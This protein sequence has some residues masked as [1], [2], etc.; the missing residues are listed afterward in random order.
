MRSAACRLHLCLAAFVLIATTCA[1]ADD[2]HPWTFPRFS[3]DAAG[4]YKAASEVTPAAGTGVI[5]LDH[6][7][8][9]VLDDQGRAAYTMYAVYKTLT[10]DAAEQWGGISVEWEPWHENRPTIRARVITSDGIVHLLDG[11]TVT[12][13]AAGNVGDNVYSDRRVVQAALPA[14]APGS[15]IELEE[16]TNETA[17]AFTG[18]IVGRCLFGRAAPVQHFRLRLEAPVSVPLRYDVLLLPT[19]QAQRAESNGRLEITFDYGPI[20][21]L[22]A[23]DDDLPSDVPAY[24]SVEFS[25]GS[26]W[27]QIAGLYGGMVDRQIAQ[28]DLRSI[29]APLLKDKRTREDKITTLLQYSDREV[30][31][32]GI[33]FGA[34]AITPHTPSETLKQRFGDCKDKATLLIAMLRAAG[35]PSYMAL[36]Q[37]AERQDIRPDLPG[38]GRFDHAIVYVP[39]KPDVWIDATDERARLGE[40][41]AADQGRL[42]LIAKPETDSL[43]LTPAS[44][45]TDNLLVEKR[46]FYLAESGPARVVEI[47]E[48]HGQLE[49]AYRYDYANPDDKDTREGLTNYVANQYLAERLDKVSTSDPADITEQFTLTLESD[50]ARRGFT[51]L[52]SSGIAIRFDTLFN[53]LPSELQQH[54]PQPDKDEK[55]SK[56]EHKKPRTA[57]YQLPE[58]F[59]TEWHYT[60]VPPPGFRMKPL[61]QDVA[62]SLGPATLVEQFS[63]GS[64]GAAH[65]LIRFDTV[66]GR[67]TIA[68]ANEMRNKIADLRDAEPIE[69]NYEPIGRALLNEGKPRE[70]FQAYRDLIAAHPNDSIF[71]LWIAKDLLAAGLGEAA[72]DEARRAVKLAPDSA[73]AQ[74]ALAEILECDLVGRRYHHG[75]DFVGAAT[76]YRAAQK[77][78][79]N[80]KYITSSLGLLLSYNNEGEL[81][82][83]GADLKDAISEYHK[84]TPEEMSRQGIANNLAFCFFYSGDF[85]KAIENARTLNPQPEAIIVAA[86]AALHGSQAGIEEARKQSSNEA[87]VKE[88]L[89]TAGWMLMR[90]RVYREAADLIDAGAS[91]ETA[92]RDLAV[93]AIL[94][95]AHRREDV[96]YPNSP[97]GI[98]SQFWAAVADKT[99]DLHKWLSMSSRNER[100]VL[101]QTDAELLK[102][103]LEADR[104]GEPRVFPYYVMA[105]VVAEVYGW[106]PEGNDASGYR[107]AFAQKAADSPRSSIIVVTEG[108]EYKILAFSRHPAALGLEVLD[109]IEAGNLD[110]A[111]VLLDWT[112]ES[113][114]LSGNGDPLDGPA[115]SR[116]W[117]TGEVA[118][119]AQMKVAAAAILV[120][121]RA[122]AQQGLAILETARASV[123]DDA[124]KVNIALALSAGYEQLEQWDKFLAISSALAH[125]YPQSRQAFVDET[126]ALTG[127]SRFQEAD[128]LARERLKRLPDDI[129]AHG[130]LVR[131]AVDRGDYALAHD[132]DRELVNTG[133]ADFG[134]MNRLAWNALFTGKVDDGDIETATQAAQLSGNRPEILHTLGCLYAEV[135][136][137]K[138]AY[139]VLIQAMNRFDLDQPDSIYWYPLGRIA[140]QLGEYDVAERDYARVEKP[141]EPMAI[142]DST[143]LLAQNRLRV[144]QAKPRA[145]AAKN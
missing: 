47:S 59:A 67:F 121:D 99:M 26:S 112:R 115:F 123:A 11:S 90:I 48:P 137:I 43:S 102:Q 66:K 139:E 5:I 38:M 88:T 52:D 138:D 125:E 86:V 13:A 12:D 16:T 53:P 23:A 113:Q 78:D 33:E 104:G 30:R 55:D 97:L 106:K 37:V 27:R 133:R 140:E 92:S 134:D 46:E 3:D 17:P 61:P 129:D 72:R 62:L 60:I 29:V 28:S 74:K 95:K 132:L 10:Q 49:S 45:S 69:I 34:A 41:P 58:P 110:G 107:L 80:D 73:V 18:G 7:E 79:P 64:D 114:P 101:Q 77:L 70:A 87:H 111:R 68:E 54:T 98:A 126:F 131:S 75:A 84:L 135:G 22:E 94:R 130:E 91:G 63:A 71:H 4:L 144:L 32:T 65:A 108:G 24:S 21:P 118:D 116:L 124:A 14:V 119:A 51:D 96:P 42:A 2:T 83:P 57:D 31:Y 89:D 1:A 40:L 145:N 105:D 15:L 9:Y 39:G 50:R 122:T 6:E 85:D 142:P 36:L 136:K 82:G 20:A 120:Q 109:R 93:A 8:S 143:Y 127:L 100:Q 81:D 44:S 56:S 76:A 25:T 35:I 128:A 117:T 141:K 19:V 103:I